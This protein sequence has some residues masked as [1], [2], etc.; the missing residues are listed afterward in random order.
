M[1]KRE[2]PAQQASKPILHYILMPDTLLLSPSPPQRRTHAS[3]PVLHAAVTS[4][5]PVPPPSPTPRPDLP[6]TATFLSHLLTP[7][8]GSQRINRWGW[9]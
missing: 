3:S 5:S 1:K 7:A 2:G 6:T 9:G 8:A 4:S